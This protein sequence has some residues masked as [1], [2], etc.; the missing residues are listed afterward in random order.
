MI[1]SHFLKNENRQA[2]WL[3]LG[4]VGAVTL[5]RTI[6]HRVIRYDFEQKV[7]LITG[8][9]RG[10][11]LEI[12]RKLA[13]KG[14]KLAI[15]ARTE[16]QLN[17]AEKE[18]KELGAEVLTIAADLT[19]QVQ[20]QQACDEVVAYFGQ[21]DVLINNAGTMLVA[22]ENVLEAED[23]QE[24]MD[25]NLW[26]AVYMTQAVLPHF[27]ERGEGRIANIS[28]IGGKIAVP[29]MLPYSVSKFALT[30][31]SEGLSAELRKDNI[32]VTTVVP[33]L[34]RTGS[35]R[36]ISLKGDHEAE[37]AWFKISDSLPGI[38]QS[39]ETAAA[40]IVEAIALGRREV[41]LTPIAKF[42]SALQGIAPGTITTL[43]QWVNEIMPASSN[44]Q[45]K[46]GFESESAAT[47]NIATKLTDEAAEQNN[48]TT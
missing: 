21:L 47:T 5:A 43:S 41:I 6:Y 42:V 44:K 2:L 31:F 25:A 35:P 33:N 14:A 48:E 1:N 40:E 16:E 20:A 9:S 8:G 45:T 4:A 36:N 39:A 46:K 32:H 13:S 24:V 23:Y 22:P 7:V 19:S 17:N 37:Y 15:C 30:A 11:G 12:A 27:R 28:S 29:H 26:S 10:L 18:L 3:T 34:M 38:S